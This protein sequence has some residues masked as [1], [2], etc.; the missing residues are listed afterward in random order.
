MRTKH[1][2]V[3][4]ALC[5]VWPA[6]MSGQS[7]PPPPPP[8][9]QAKPTTPA[10]KVTARA[11]QVNVIVQDKNGQPVTG[12]TKEN[13]TILDQG[14][15]QTLASFSEQTNKVSTTVVK[16]AAPN[17]FTNR[18][19]ERY[20][21]PPSVSVI[22]I[23]SLNMLN[24]GGRVS[25]NN[26]ASAR[27]QVVKFLKKLEPQDRVALY[28]LSD[29]IYIVHD[30]TKDTAELLHAMDEIPHLQ[31]DQGNA[32]PAMDFAPTAPGSGMTNPQ[33]ASEGIERADEVYTTNRVKQT[34]AALEII[35]KHLGGLPG[36]K[37]LIWI[38]GSFP[39]LIYTPAG[40]VSFEPQISAAA[41][42]LSNANVALYAVDAR[43]LT[44]SPSDPET[45]NSMTVLAN[46][47][48]GRVFRNTND[49]SAAIRQAIDDSNVSYVLSYYPNHNQWDGRFREIT[50][51]VDRPGV[52]IRARRGYF[53]M[54]DAAVSPKSDE[55]IMVEAANNS[56]ESSTLGMDVQADPVDISGTRQ[57]KA[58]VTIDPAQLLLAKTE[59]R[60][61]D[62]VEVKWVQI[63]ANGR[64]VGS[65]SQ[66][67]NLNIPQADYEK[68]LRKGLTFSGTVKLKKDA[69]DVRIV[70]RDSGNGSVGTVN[71]PLERLFAVNN[72]QTPATR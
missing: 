69:A 21:V 33:W 29:K 27:E 13:F 4:M 7:V 49:F 41:K 25:R 19:E 14:Q 34:A 20:G 3:A 51:R 31:Q 48:G 67:L 23:D 11:V 60:R 39:F 9:D 12:L 54:P 28:F 42:A 16:A 24:N 58:R 32:T 47:T 46:R 55:E 57:L 59:D 62:T 45:V 10:L 70:V 66:T 68:F 53:A 5:L 2:V 22:L 44:T 64:V 43:G 15:P 61:M 38:S 35:A 36:R 17:T 50:I 40:I 63:D 71:I 1:A 26:M 52:S 37:N 8:T 30:F 18:V 56:L 6:R 72:I 65:T